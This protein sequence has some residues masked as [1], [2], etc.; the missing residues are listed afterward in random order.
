LKD[1]IPAPVTPVPRKKDCLVIA[2]Q[3]V[4]VKKRIISVAELLLRQIL[5]GCLLLVLPLRSRPGSVYPLLLPVFPLV[6]PALLSPC[7]P[8][9]R[10]AVPA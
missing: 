8:A 1:I 9:L 10:A 4:P 3:Q 6:S 7:Q 2:N 5:Q